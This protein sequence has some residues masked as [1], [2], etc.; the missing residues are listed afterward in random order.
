[1]TTH[2]PPELGAFIR[3]VGRGYAYCYQVLRVWTPTKED[4][5]EG[6]DLKRWGMK[7]GRPFND[8]HL[9]TCW[10]TGLRRVLPGVWRDPW[11]FDTPRWRCCPLYY[12]LIDT[13]PDGQLQLI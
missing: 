4:P 11:E 9:S 5:R 8:G 2:Q 10:L 6:L 13:G 1:M 3:P 12:R 7:D